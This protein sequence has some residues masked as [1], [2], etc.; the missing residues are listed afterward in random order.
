[1]TAHQFQFLAA[2]HSAPDD[3][4][5]VSKRHIGDN[6]GGECRA[7]YHQHHTIEEPL[8]EPYA[9]NAHDADAGSQK[10]DGDKDAGHTKAV[11]HHIVRQLVSPRPH[12]VCGSIGRVIIQLL[13]FGT[14]E[15]MGHHR[16]KNIHRN[17]CQNR[18][19]H[20]TL[21]AVLLAFLLVF[22]GFYT[23]LRVASQP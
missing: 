9:G 15:Q 8:V 22:D 23:V 18:T 6:V 16:Q 12:P 2:D 19:P 17:Q 20:E 4:A 3:I 14:G 1:M 13:V 5:V 7:P 21:V 10:K 11:V